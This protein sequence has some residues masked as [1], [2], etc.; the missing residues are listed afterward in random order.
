V[1]ADLIHIV[2]HGE[3]F[4]PD[5]IVYGRL[6]GFGLSERG[7][8]MADRA[9]TVL[10]TRPVARIF[11]SPLQRAQESAVSLTARTGVLVELDERLNEGLNVFEGSRVSFSRILKNPS[12]WREFRNPWKPSWGEPY[13]DIA[14]RMMDMVE[15]AHDSVE[16]GEVVMVSHQVAIWVLHRYVAGIPLP[17]LP[18]NRRCSLSSI[19]T[20]KK[21]GDKWKE[22]SYREPAADLLVEAIDQGAH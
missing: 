19:T 12:L 8:A 15:F 17:H 11:S 7:V 21:V 5:R 1:P 3:V 4:N 18:G 20:V 13:R 6:D 2:R 22:E 9:A 14:A 16:E 10:A